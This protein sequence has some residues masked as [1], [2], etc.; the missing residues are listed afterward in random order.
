MIGP[1]TW[2][3]RCA[4]NVDLAVEAA[5]VIGKRLWIVRLAWQLLPMAATLS[6]ERSANSDA[7]Q[8]FRLDTLAFWH[9]SED[10]NEAAVQAVSPRQCV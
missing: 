10:G 1:P 3:V 2:D 8:G 6:R 5:G 9:C 7:Q 4:E